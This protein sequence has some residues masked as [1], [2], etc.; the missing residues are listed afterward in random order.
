MTTNN[1]G[2]LNKGG[3]D[4]IKNIIEVPLSERTP[5]QSAYLDACLTA[6][7]YQPQR[8]YSYQDWGQGGP[9]RFLAERGIEFN[10]VPDTHPVARSGYDGCECNQPHWREMTTFSQTPAR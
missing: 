3:V 5:Q 2:K 7:A 10:P 6:L 9:V 8:W 4:A 1:S